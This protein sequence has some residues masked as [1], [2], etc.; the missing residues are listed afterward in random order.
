MDELKK[1]L[2]DVIKLFKNSSNYAYSLLRGKDIKSNI[3]FSNES[4]KEI[5]SR[6]DKFEGLNKKFEVLIDNNEI[7]DKTREL[8][9]N[10]I[11]IENKPILK[12]SIDIK[13]KIC[14]IIR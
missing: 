10:S 4:E 3:H 5:L 6:L 7:R 14:S 1:L 11:K 8:D 9:E 2:N 13:N 12:I